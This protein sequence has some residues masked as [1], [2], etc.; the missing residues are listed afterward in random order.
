MTTL[1]YY[2]HSWAFSGLQLSYLEIIWPFWVLL[3]NLLEGTTAVLSLG[4]IIS[5]HGSKTFCVLCLMPCRLW[6]FSVWLLRTG[7]SPHSLWVQALSF[8]IFLTF[9]LFCFCF[10]PLV[11]FLYTC[12]DQY[13]AEHLTGT[14]ADLRSSLCRS[15]LWYHALQIL[16][17]LVS[18]GLTPLWFS[19]PAPRPGYSLK[20]VHWGN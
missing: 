8:L 15:L 19:L 16:A 7:T 3:L 1:Y 5:H 13:S 18:Q 6:G 10:C 9:V 12:A 4:P 11:V 20:A 17:A 2:K 14:P